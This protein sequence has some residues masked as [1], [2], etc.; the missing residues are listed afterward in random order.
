MFTPETPSEACQKAPAEAANL[1]K[2]EGS[3]GCRQQQ[4]QQKT[5][6]ER[7]QLSVVVY[8][9]KNIVSQVKSPWYRIRE[10]I[11]LGRSGAPQPH[12]SETNI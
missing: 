3:I 10:P 12:N 1:R 11:A 4:Q 5:N 7:V 2:A 8:R 6:E 9:N